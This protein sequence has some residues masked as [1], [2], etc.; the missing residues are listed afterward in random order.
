MWTMSSLAVDSRSCCNNRFGSFVSSLRFPPALPQQRLI[1]KETPDMSKTLDA[2]SEIIRNP[3]HTFRKADDRPVKAQKHRYE[4]R[5]VKGYM[6][7]GDWE[8]DGSE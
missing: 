6:K 3:K 8:Q 4:R 1:R 7:H 2:I 5:K